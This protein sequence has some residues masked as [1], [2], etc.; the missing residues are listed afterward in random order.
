[1]PVFNAVTFQSQGTR[2]YQEDRYMVGAHRLVVCD[3]MG[4]HE[5]G[6]DAAETAVRGLWDSRKMRPGLALQA[7][8]LGV[9]QQVLSLGRATGRRKMGCTL[10][11]TE[12]RSDGA[13]AWGHVGD[14]RIYWWKRRAG[15]LHVLTVDHNPGGAMFKA[16]QIEQEEYEAAQYQTF[17]LSCIGGGMA[18]EDITIDTGVIRPDLG[19]ILMLATD[20]VF[21]PLRHSLAGL[22]LPAAQDWRQVKVVGE[23]ILTESLRRGDG[24]NKTLVLARIE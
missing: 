20:G 1:M 7:A 4:G 9:H 3:G 21:G 12:L 10:I 13:V 23:N 15:T 22:L 16:G 8:I 14:S 24:D 6:A 17:L 5:G 11:T 19:D 18:A 2:P